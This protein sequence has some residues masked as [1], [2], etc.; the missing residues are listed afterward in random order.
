MSVAKIQMRRGASSEWETAPIPVLDEGEWGYDTTT[1]QVRIG[2]GVSEWTDL[3]PFYPGQ[4]TTGGGTGVGS[5]PALIIA[6]YN[7]PSAVKSLAHVICTGVNDHTTINNAINAANNVISS[8]GTGKVGA[9]ILCN[10]DFSLGGPILVPCRG[11]SISGMGWNTILRKSANAFVSTGAAAGQGTP[12]ALIKMATTAAAQAASSV[13]IED[14]Y[15]VCSNNGLVTGVYLEGNGD[16]VQI[17]T[18]GYPIAAAV[19]DR[20]HRIRGVRVDNCANG[21]W[22]SASGSTNRHSFIEG[23]TVHTVAS[24]G[25]A[26]YIDTSDNEII[27]CT[28]AGGRSANTIGFNLV[29]ASTIISH[30]KAFYFDATGCVGFHFNASRIS[31]TALEGQDCYTSFKVSKSQCSIVGARADTQIAAYIAFDL[32]SGTNGTFTGL[33]A[34]LRVAPGQY[35]AATLA[36]PDTSVAGTMRVDAFID[37]DTNDTMVKP[38]AKGDAFTAVTG[39]GTLPTG[40]KATITLYKTGVYAN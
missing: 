13:N 33:Y 5:A 4:S 7:S 30:C 40:V 25:S 22:I 20:F 19:D 10:G 31:G 2:D 37:T 15:L 1:K 27:N 17:S 26:F 28:A 16:S 24:G 3:I 8:S 21:I 14:L 38:V 32:R 36:L 29:G 35:S 9:V 12:T 23:C 34:S 39:S 18:Y 6:A 11:F